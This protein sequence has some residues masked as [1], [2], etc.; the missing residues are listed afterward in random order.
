M[1]ALLMSLEVVIYLVQIHK[2]WLKRACPN[3]YKLTTIPC[4]YL[5]GL[6]GIRSNNSGKT[7]LTLNFRS[8]F[9]FNLKT[10]IDIKK[11]ED[12]LVDPE[13]VAELMSRPSPQAYIK[14]SVNEG[15][16]YI[17]PV[18][19]RLF[20]RPPIVCLLSDDTQKPVPNA[21]SLTTLDMGSLVKFCALS[22]WSKLFT[23]LISNSLSARGAP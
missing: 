19:F 11:D 16:S 18:S 17:I 12:D 6:K 1:A 21:E 2:K 13:S 20:T 8:P 23:D 3:L 4:L 5:E 9:V 14:I 7:L 15:N 10:T 22:F